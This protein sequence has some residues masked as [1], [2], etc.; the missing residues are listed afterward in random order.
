M[1]I[2]KGMTYKIPRSITEKQLKSFF[3]DLGTE[4]QNPFRLASKNNIYEKFR[5]EKRDQIDNYINQYKN[6]KELVL[7][8]QIQI[9]LNLRI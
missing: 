3:D 9:I 8:I 7:K 1:Q 4:N 2:Q 5:I 6:I